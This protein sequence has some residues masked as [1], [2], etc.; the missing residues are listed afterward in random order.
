ME[1]YLASLDERGFVDASWS[2][3]RTKRIKAGDRIF[4]LRQGREPRGIMASG[5]AESAPYKEEHWDESHNDEALYVDVRFDSL[6]NPEQDGVLPLSR[7]KG[8]KLAEV[9]WPTRISGIS[10]PSEA[11]SQLENLWLSFLEERGQ[12]PIVIPEEVTTPGLY[13][14]GAVRRIAVNAYERDPRARKAC[15]EHYGTMCLACGFD[16]GATYGALGEGF[17]HV[18]HVVPLS[19]I[20]E[21]YIVDPVHDLRPVCPNCHAMLHK[22]KEVLE[23]DELKKFL[24]KESSDNLND[25]RGDAES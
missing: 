11:A 12:S 10:V 3:G 16:F 13:G 22:H 25:T 23:I 19:Q 24:R 21:S 17:I 7:L 18:H 14:E 5:Y 1:T 9:N 20:G 4:L 15:M 2:C 6:L 8:G